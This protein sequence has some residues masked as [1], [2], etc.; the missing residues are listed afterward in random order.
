MNEDP[1]RHAPGRDPGPDPGATTSDHRAGRTLRLWPRFH[2]PAFQPGFRE[3]LSIHWAAN[4]LML[5]RPRDI[6]VFTV[7][8]LIPAAAYAAFIT[9]FPALFTANA[10]VPAEVDRL[11]AVSLATLL[12]WGIAQHLAFMQAMDM[13]YVPHVRTAL[14]HRGVP[15]C[16]RCGHLLPP[17]TPDVACSECGAPGSSATIDDSGR[18]AATDASLANPELPSNPGREAPRR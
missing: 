17:E 4:L 10:L 1:R 14:R 2:D 9:A 8:S 15:V 6:V 3:N 12:V 16:L 7:V 11:L 13:T 18:A 5:R